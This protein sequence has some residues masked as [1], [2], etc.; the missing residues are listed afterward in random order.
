[1]SEGAAHQMAWKWPARNAIVMRAALRGSFRLP[2]R[3]DVTRPYR[4][5]LAL[6]ATFVLLIPLAPIS[7]QRLHGA[8][9]L[10]DS[11]T[12]ARGVIVVATGD[13]GALVRR[14][15]TNQ[16]GNFELPLPHAGRYPV[17]GLRIC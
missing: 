9:L 14:A 3:Q 5:L 1:M 7:A 2:Y 12:P 11:T 17:S 13:N 4:W 15:L 16:R 8:V 6:G 10:P